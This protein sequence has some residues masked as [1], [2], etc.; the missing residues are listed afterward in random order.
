M[1]RNRKILRSVVLSFALFTGI[2][3]ALFVVVTTTHAAPLL[4]APWGPNVRVNDDATGVAN[5]ETP[6]LAASKTTNDVYAVWEDQRSENPDIFFAHSTDGGETWGAGVLVNHDVGNW[7]YGPDIAVSAAGLLHVVWYDYRTASAD[8]YYARSTDGGQTWSAEIRINDVYTGSQYSPAIAALDDT[9]CIVWVDGRVD[10]NRDVYVD[11]S[12]D[13]GLTWGTDTRVN[14]DI[15]GAFYHYAPDI[16]LGPAGYPHVVW[17]D[18]RNEN[19]DIFYTHFLV[20]DGWSSNVRL[21][22][23]TTG[24]QQYPAIAVS[25]DDTVYALWIDSSSGSGYVAGDV[26]INGGSTWGAD[27]QVS[28]TD[29]TQSA[30]VA[31]DGQG[32]AW[33]T[34]DV[35]SDTTYRLYADSYGLNGWSPDDMLITETTDYLEVPAIAAG[36]TRV[37]VAWQQLL[38]DEDYD[39]LLSIWD[40]AAWGDAIQVNDEGDARQA[41]PSIAI[42]STNTLYAAWADYRHDTNDGALYADYSLDGGATWGRDVRVDD[43][44]PVGE[45]PAL[46]A[47]GG[48]TVHVAWGAPMVNLDASDPTRPEQGYG[49]IYY[50]RSGDGGLTWGVD[51]ELTDPETNDA[52]SPD[53]VAAGQSVYVVWRQY[54]G[55]YL[56]SSADGG[57]TWIS[58]TLILTSTGSMDSPTITRD[59]AGT[60]HLAWVEYLY[61]T[62]IQ[63]HIGYAR[64]LDGGV[65]WTSR[66]FVDMG[67]AG[68]LRDNPDI[69]VN[70]VNGYVHLVWDDNRNGANT[71]FHNVSSSGG[72]TWGT[73]PAAILTAPAIEPSI[74]VDGGGVAYVLWQDGLEDDTDVA[75]STSEN[76]GVSWSVPGRVN[77]DAT[78]FPQRQPAVVIGDSVY[79]VWNDSRRAN[80][81]IESA[82]L[83]DVCPL[84][85]KDVSISGPSETQTGVPVD[86]EAVI[87]PPDATPPLTFVWTPK[88]AAGQGTAK[89]TYY[90][91]EPSTYNVQVVASNCGGTVTTTH[92][93]AVTVPVKALPCVEGRIYYATTA[94]SGVNVELILGSS[95]SGSVEQSTTTDTYGRYRFCNVEPGAYML[96]RYGLSAE[97]V[98]WV[99]DSLTMGTSSVIKNLDLPKKMTLLTPTNGTTIYTTI[100][101]M[102]WQSLLE[103]DRYTFQLNKTADWTLVEHTNN[104]VGTAHQVLAPLNW[105]TGYTWQI[106][107]YAGTHWV[108]TTDDEF[109]FSTSGF[110]VIE[111][112]PIV[113]IDS[114]LRLEEASEGVVV[115]KLVGDNTGK[116]THDYVD[117]VAYVSTYASD[118]ASNADVILTVPG[119]VLG[120]P[121]NTWVRNGY[122]STQ[123]PA[124]S[125]YLG[126]GQ[127]KVTTNLPKACYW[128]FCPYR[129]QVVWRFDIPDGI[130]PQTLNLQ[131]R[132]Q[133]T[134]YWVFGSFSDADLRLV[135]TAEA[136]IVTNREQLYDNYTSW[137][138]TNLLAK[139]YNVAQGAP[140]ND[141]PL[142]VIYNA[143]LY[144]TD[145][146]N[147]DN[148]AVNYT[149][150]TT[151]NAVANEVDDLIEDWVE[152]GTWTWSYH[153]LFSTTVS[154]DIYPY[155]VLLV[156]DDDVLPFYRYNDPYNNED[157]WSVTLAANPQ[158]RATDNDYILTDTPYGDLWGGTDWRL[159]DLEL[160][161]GRLLGA[162]ADDMR[163]LLNNSLAT[164]GGTWRAVMASVDG[165]E[166]GYNNPSCGAGSV[167]DVL[168]V[169]ARLGARG[170]NVRND[171]ETPHTVDV[172]SP[173]DAGWESGFRTAANGGMDIFFIGGHD[174][175][176]GANIPGD[177]FTPD[178]TC[179]GAACDFNRFD[180][181]HPLT[182]IVGCHGGLPVP[183]IGGR[184]G[185]DDNMVYDIVHEGGRAYI[186]ATGFSYGSPGSLCYA[187]WGEK[188]MQH[189]FDEFLSAGTESRT[190]G[191]ALRRAKDVYPFGQYNPGT[192]ATDGDALDRKTVTEFNLYGVPWQRLDYPGGMQAAAGDQLS[193]TSLQPTAVRM[194]AGNIVQADTYR[195]TRTITVDIA[196]YDVTQV[197][198]GG[199]TYDVLSIVGGDMAVAPEL[200]MLPYVKGY[201]LT[202]PISATVQS[203]AL[204]SST[205]GSDTSHEVPIIV[206]DPWSEGGTTFTTTTDINTYYPALDNL[207]VE[208]MQDGRMLFTLFPIQHNPTS[209]A[210]RF[211]S[212]MV[213]EVVYDAPVALAVSSVMP[214]ADT[215]TPGTPVSV[216][217]LLENVTDE[218]LTVTSTLTLLDAEG[219]EVGWQDD[220]PFSVPS[221]GQ[222]GVEIGWDG[223]LPEGFYGLLLTF[224]KDDVM[225]GLGTTHVNVTG[226]ALT[227]LEVPAVTL[228]MSDTATF[229][230]TFANYLAEAVTVT[231]HLALYDGEGG[232]VAT[233]PTQTAM[234]AA[235]DTHVF[236]FTWE[237][238]A[239]A[240]GVHVAQARIVREDETQYGPLT[241]EFM[242]G[243]VLKN[244]FLPIVLRNF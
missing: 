133:K 4:D 240:G 228:A 35:Y 115:N 21:N 131:S 90:W 14:D 62:A 216:T 66:Q 117:V 218:L 162:T 37:Y 3:A 150:E 73:T 29:Q 64:S 166:L 81:D 232:V 151:A 161:V 160:A 46:G 126:S 154:V 156:G 40:G 52:S 77:D 54:D 238:G 43:N 58:P 241:D 213:L 188:L 33:A 71:I 91:Q 181:D 122:G 76:D 179:S 178:D 198:T 61:I 48:D 203:V 158:I 157:D 177:D 95:A 163:Y 212:Q 100:P 26:S 231:A 136:L 123:T 108:G 211:C 141:Q 92:R 51:R 199:V 78:T 125:T 22:D 10:S 170:F 79:A 205:C 132:V 139:L 1:V 110:V 176:N 221:D 230:M 8:I 2:I 31:I 148:T 98:D 67:A 234:T 159:G 96:K 243:S 101:T 69:A 180:N 6:A 19:W 135:N 87:A 65:T 47:V 50:D 41:Y 20:A 185:V 13:G 72:A 124:T 114:S 84:P 190:I 44:H 116:T 196:G 236:E 28:T 149:S 18:N 86:L 175:Y 207:V 97:Y 225:M 118:A 74:A 223:M 191:D 235:N 186:G 111:I 57:T 184:G 204:V 130:S 34:W 9:V 147:W 210:T 173:F 168:N 55:L 94:L 113:T 242:V 17:Y 152:D 165:W 219:H 39:I 224:W 244:I 164:D 75:Y 7:Q 107:A 27:W 89:A 220:G 103:A 88:P 25:D 153:F 104:I 172:L 83:Q 82:G 169:P 11:C 80:W 45:P 222:Q 226:G 109:T 155:Y 182:F 112:P 194:D 195:Y 106:D 233:L 237:V 144:D 214:L 102:T 120:T 209:N 42:G 23:V 121:T 24:T 197:M 206:A 134:G 202:L 15:G 60:L 192:T 70:P 193:T 187:T 127:Y 142:G 208:Q 229:S 227:A 16:A 56:T 138:V 146:R 32:T 215:F 143:D 12:A 189:F 137:E 85:L 145:V 99:A 38:P 129:K 68:T 53:L 93:V 140:H 36:A 63:Y 200:P 30:G 5:Q 119:N 217:V 128:W 49:S 239:S 183:D 201:T 171:S 59:A 105:N 167:A 174:S